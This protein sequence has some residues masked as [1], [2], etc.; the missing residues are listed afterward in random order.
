M[1]GISLTMRLVGMGNIPGM[2]VKLTLEIGWVIKWMD[3]EKRFGQMAKVIKD[4]TSMTKSMVRE[5][6][7][8]TMVKDMKG[9]GL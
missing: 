5:C 7:H 9:N 8:G 4:I 6:F 3:M 2:M 1:K